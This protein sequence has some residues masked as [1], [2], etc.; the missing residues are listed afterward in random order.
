MLWLTSLK[1]KI[2]PS[3]LKLYVA[4]EL[5]LQY[6]ICTVKKYILEN[7]KLF[8][9]ELSL[10]PLLPDTK[11]PNLFSLYSFV[12]ST[13]PRTEHEVWRQANQQRKRTPRHV[14]P[15]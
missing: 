14:V 15:V 13:I 10:N 3:D 12:G 6:L 9:S 2:S 5:N 4:D 1:K 7:C 11:D 8:C